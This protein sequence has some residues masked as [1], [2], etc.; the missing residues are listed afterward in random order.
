LLQP[1]TLMERPLPFGS[2]PR[3]MVF[4]KPVPS[5]LGETGSK[6]PASL[7]RLTKRRSP[8]P[9]LEEPSETRIMAPGAE[10]QGNCFIITNGCIGRRVIEACDALN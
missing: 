10:P 9:P 1:G 5:P 2:T 7:F 3:R 4:D 8:Y 6:G